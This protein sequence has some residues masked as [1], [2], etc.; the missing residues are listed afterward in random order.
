MRFKLFFIWVDPK[1]GILPKSMVLVS[2]LLSVDCGGRAA[3]TG[4]EKG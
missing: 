1:K 3:K 2:S 4:I